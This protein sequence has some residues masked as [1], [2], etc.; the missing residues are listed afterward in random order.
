MKISAGIALTVYE[1]EIPRLRVGVKMK[2]GLLHDVLGGQCG[3]DGVEQ[4]AIHSEK[5][6]YVNTFVRSDRVRAV[7]FGAARAEEAWCR[8]RV[9]TVG[10]PA[11]WQ[12]GKNAWNPR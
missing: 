5:R 6:F 3:N 8:I 9:V 12:R 2:G 7:G 10:K 11:G 1:A 4:S